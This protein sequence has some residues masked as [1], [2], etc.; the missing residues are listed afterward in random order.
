MILDYLSK[1]GI[2]SDYP[3]VSKERSK[4]KTGRTTSIYLYHRTAFGHTPEPTSLVSTIFV[5]L[6]T[7]NTRRLPG[8]S[9]ELNHHMLA[10]TFLQT[11]QTRT[12]SPTGCPGLRAVNSGTP[13]L[14]ITIGPIRD[15]MEWPHP[16]HAMRTCN[17]PQ[18][19]SLETYEI[20]D[21]ASRTR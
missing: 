10:P 8:F 13:W 17:T 2:L 5:Q 18:T 19:V 4:I 3:K 1:V 9:Q 11:Q 12:R 20:R 16:G 14:N 21:Q 15:L 6:S 7:Q